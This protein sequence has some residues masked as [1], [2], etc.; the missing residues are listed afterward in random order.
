MLDKDSSPA[1]GWW[2]PPTLVHCS[3]F[4][5]IA[6]LIPVDSQPD[7]LFFFLRAC[8]LPAR[9]RHVLWSATGMCTLTCPLLHKTCQCVGKGTRPRD[10]LVATVLGERI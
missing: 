3:G 9:M 7:I 2:P 10:R 4:K 8:L 6:P 5:P 1:T